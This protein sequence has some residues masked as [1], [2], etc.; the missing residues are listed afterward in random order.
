[1]VLFPGLKGKEM[2]PV[3]EITTKGWKLWERLI[4]RLIER[5]LFF[6]SVLLSLFPKSGY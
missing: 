2:S 6:D 4:K 5:G 3:P 1:M